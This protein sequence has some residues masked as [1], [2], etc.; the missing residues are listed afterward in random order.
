MQPTSAEELW[1]DLFVTT[2]LQTLFKNSVYV[3]V[4]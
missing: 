4:A 3:K 2:Y 1:L